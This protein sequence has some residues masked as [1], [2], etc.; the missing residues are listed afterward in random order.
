MEPVQTTSVSGFGDNY[1]AVLENLSKGPVLMLQQ[2]RLAAVLVA[3]GA[4]NRLLQELE[5]LRDI[6]D[7]L[8]AQIAATPG[9]PETEAADIGELEAMAGHAVPA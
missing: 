6:V 8:E 4:W 7:V 5:E 9:E 1:A 2:S 3:P